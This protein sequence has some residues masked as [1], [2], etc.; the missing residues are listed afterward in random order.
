MAC[1]PLGATAV[2]PGI[3]ASSPRVVWTPVTLP[4][5]PLRSFCP[6]VCCFTPRRVRVHQASG[7]VTL[8]VRLTPPV[9]FRWTFAPRFCLRFL[10]TEKVF[11]I[12]VERV[13]L[14]KNGVWI[15]SRCSFLPHEL[16]HQPAG[17]AG[18]AGALRG[19]CA[20]TASLSHQPGASGWLRGAE[21]PP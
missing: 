18:W 20:G 3:G 5:G 8:S 4:A 7:R 2:S 10:T 6:V 1:L 17:S 21:S 12:V 14:F 13:V 15:W 11:V 16:Q 19:G 9:I